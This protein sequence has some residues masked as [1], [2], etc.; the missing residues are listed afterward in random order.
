M[1]MGEDE[2]D[3]SFSLRAI[4]GTTSIVLVHGLGLDQTI[5]HLVQLPERCARSKN[6]SRHSSTPPSP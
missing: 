5:N 6:T 3:T 1:S 4:P 2:Q